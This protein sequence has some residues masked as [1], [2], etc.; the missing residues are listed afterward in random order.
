V[1]GNGFERR[2]LYEVELRR[3]PDQPRK[4]FLI[5]TADEL[6]KR[7]IDLHQGQ[8]P[9]VSHALSAS[10][11]AGDIQLWFADPAMQR[12]MEATEV[13]GRLPAPAG[14]FL[15]L[16]DANLSASKANVGLVKTVTY[17][18]RQ[19]GRELHARLE[20]VVRNEA[21]PDPDINPYYN[22]FLRVYVPRG[23]ELLA[24]RTGQRDE[25]KANDGPYS[26]FSQSLEVRPR[27]EQRLEFEY[28]LPPS[29][30]PGGH[31][32]L[33]WMRQAGTPRDSFTVLVGR[34]AEQ[35]D[36]DDRLLIVRAD[37]RP[38]PLIRFL[39]SRWIVKQLT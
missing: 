35:A 11:G 18:V 28:V 20:V 16:V 26:V 19:E 8:L 37:L 9:G 5:E 1:T 27:S 25:G 17:R 13:S 10:V 24:P 30:A 38:N 31:Y 21:E 22:G 2:V 4:R 6:F 23:S 12:P 15:M 29:A 33:A 39:R 32:H 14:D 7:L 3:P 36:P 34:Q